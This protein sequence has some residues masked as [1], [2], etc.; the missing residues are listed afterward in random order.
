[1]KPACFM[2]GAKVDLSAFPYKARRRA[3]H[4]LFLVQ[5]GRNPDDWKPMPSVGARAA[6]L[7]GC[8]GN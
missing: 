2:G 3:G 4:E 8:E 7:F 5:V 1:M 6:A